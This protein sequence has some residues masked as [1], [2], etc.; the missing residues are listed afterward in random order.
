MN[1]WSHR[2][3]PNKPQAG[4]GKG[5]NKGEVGRTEACCS[6]Q[7]QDLE[8]NTHEEHWAGTSPSPGRSTENFWGEHCWLQGGGDP[9]F[10][11]TQLTAACSTDAPHPGPGHT[12][13][14]ITRNEKAWE[15]P[16]L[17]SSFI[18]SRPQERFK[19]WQPPNLRPSLLCPSLLP[20]TLVSPPWHPPPLTLALVLSDQLNLSG[21]SFPPALPPLFAPLYDRMLQGMTA[22]AA[23]PW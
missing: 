11:T 13:A 10:L 15:Q 6:Q 1:P 3:T 7:P 5:K 14:L 16:S 9:Q 8:R 21:C 23:F 17:K 2:S 18:R 19:Q 12:R 20:P 22:S 4:D